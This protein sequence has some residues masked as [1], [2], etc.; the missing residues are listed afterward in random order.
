MVSDR[1]LEAIHV[2]GFVVVLLRAKLAHDDD[3]LNATFKVPEVTLRHPDSRVRIASLQHWRSVVG[4]FRTSPQAPSSTPNGLAAD[5]V[6]LWLLRNAIVDVVMRPLV[7]C[8]RDEALATVLSAACD[9][10][11]NLIAVAVA[12]FNAY[13]RAVAPLTMETCKIVMRNSWKLWWE[14]MVTQV[15]VVLARRIH[16]TGDAIYVVLRDRTHGLVRRM[17]HVDQHDAD[18]SETCNDN[19]RDDASAMGKSIESLSLTNSPL[20]RAM[21]TAVET[22]VYQEQSIAMLVMFQSTVHCIS[23]LRSIDP[24]DAN[25]SVVLALWHGMVRRLETALMVHGPI[26]GEAAEVRKLFRRLLTKCCAFMFGC[27]QFQAKSAA[28]LRDPETAALVGADVA[29]RHRM[30]LLE[31]VVEKLD[32]RCFQYVLTESS[33][34][35]QQALEHKAA[36]VLEELRR[37]AHADEANGGPTKVEQGDDALQWLRNEFVSDGRVTSVLELVGYTMILDL[38]MSMPRGRQPSHAS[39]GCIVAVNMPALAMAMATIFDK[40]CAFEIVPPAS[41]HVFTTA[42]HVLQSMAQA[43]ER[44]PYMDDTLGRLAPSI[45]SFAS[46]FRSKWTAYTR[47]CD[48]K[49]DAPIKADTADSMSSMGSLPSPCLLQKRASLASDGHRKRHVSSVGDHEGRL[50]STTPPVEPRRSDAIRPDLVECKEPFALIKHHFPPSFRQLAGFFNIHTIGDLCAKT[51][52]DV[53]A[54]SLHDPV[55]TVHKALDEFV[56]RRERLNT[57]ANKSPMKRKLP[58]APFGAAA[59]Q[60]VDR[61]SRSPKRRLKS[62]MRSLAEDVMLSDDGQTASAK[63]ADVVKFSVLGPDGSVRVIRPGEDSQSMELDATK[64]SPPERSPD[65]PQPCDVMGSDSKLIALAAKVVSHLERCDAYVEKIKAQILLGR[66]TSHQ[67]TACWTI[68]AR[69]TIGAALVEANGIMAKMAR[70]IGTLMEP[71]AQSSSS[72]EMSGA[73]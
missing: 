12:D 29:L 14:D 46:E 64:G 30:D 68:D 59:P 1:P 61:P 24:S 62:A 36:A 19:E 7:V 22:L 3:L 23:T 34:Q 15:L 26:V 6:A 49:V 39:T 69:T 17:W 28:S 71:S 66:R 40:F 8:F 70:D 47:R 45:P 27:T 57:L 5:T 73:S 55:N 2:W 20:P 18:A 4:I 37:A 33:G 63:I 21:V 48:R 41:R 52:A 10:W 38:L 16:Q 43:L 50:A 35:L 67:P 65:V 13:C 9:T 32:V 11:H 51:E 31:L 58:V 60:G 42:S 54:M 56:G 44:H 25:R 72:F 53:A